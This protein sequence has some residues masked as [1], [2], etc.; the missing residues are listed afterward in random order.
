MRRRWEKEEELTES[1]SLAMCGISFPKRKHHPLRAF[2]NSITNVKIEERAD[3]NNPK[4]A[5]GGKKHTEQ[6][7]YSLLLH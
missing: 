6:A 5:R 1:A 3:C 7:I 2:L 4:K